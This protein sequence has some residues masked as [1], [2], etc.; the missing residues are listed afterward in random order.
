MEEQTNY[1]RYF[2]IDNELVA[3]IALP[4]EKIL[5]QRCI[6]NSISDDLAD[7]GFTGEELP[8]WLFVTVG[9]A[10]ELRSSSDHGTYGCRAVIV[11]CNVIGHYL[12]RLIGSVYFGELRDF[13]RLDI[14]LPCKY[15]LSQSSNL[16]ELTD[17]WLKNKKDLKDN[18]WKH[19]DPNAWMDPDDKENVEDSVPLIAKVTHE[20]AVIDL[21]EK[22]SPD[23]YLHLQLLIPLDPPRMIETVAKVVTS[24]IISGF[25]NKLSKHRTELIYDLINPSDRE[26]I[27]DYVSSLQVQHMGEICKDAQYEALYKKL[28]NE[29]SHVDPSRIYK[30][31]LITFILIIVGFYFFKAANQYRKGHE[32]GLI[33]KTFEDGIRN[34]MEKFK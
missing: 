8:E 16:D 32:K 17:A 21:A 2:L 34:Y 4:D 6:I 30:K 3:N 5:Q 22:I 15:T 13:Q 18:G 11:Y 19:R 26:A 10:L 14:Y 1:S 25:A 28:Q 33:E 24:E 31:I 23:M 29:A 27:A 12:I 9:S 7:I 20:N